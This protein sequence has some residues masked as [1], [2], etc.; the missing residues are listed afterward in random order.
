MG[1]VSKTILALDVSTTSTGYAVYYN[2]DLHTY[3]TVSHKS[4]D[5]LER[6]RFMAETIHM[7]DKIKPITHVVVEDTYVSKN[8]NT[9][10]KLCLAQGILLGSLPNAELIQVYPTVWKAHFGLTKNKSARGDQKA[11]SMSVAEIITLQSVKN[12]DEADA[13]LIGKYVWD[14]R[15]D[16]L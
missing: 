5:W 14:K 11:N 6:V 1:S 13:V 4:K 9:V 12:D 8:V 7:M 16:L 10:K 3:G 15:E 2:G